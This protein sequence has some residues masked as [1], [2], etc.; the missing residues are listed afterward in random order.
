VLR[1]YLVRHAIA[2]DAPAD[3]GLVDAFRPLTAKG[4]R[5]FKRVARRLAD[6][7]EPVESIFTSPALRAVQ[8]AE[9]LAATLGVEEVRV[10]DELRPDCAAAEL[11]ARLSVGAGG[12]GFAGDGRRAQLAAR[13]RAGVALVG[14][15]R[16]LGELAAMLADS[17]ADEAMRLHF[18]RGSIARIDVPELRAG[19]HGRPRWWL[20]P[21]SGSRR[22]G[23]P[24]ERAA[25][26]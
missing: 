25:R 19:A 6:L 1:V 20:Q 16:Q 21:A 10:L 7:D 15:K 24:L 13:D 22:H 26:S 9:L 17:S 4:R 12:A 18:R 23:L 5:R 8:T 14:H 2:E 11:F 3:A